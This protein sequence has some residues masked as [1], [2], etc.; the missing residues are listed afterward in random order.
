MRIQCF[1]FPCRFF[2]PKQY[3]Y[4]VKI[5]TVRHVAVSHVIVIVNNLIIAPCIML[6]E[7]IRDAILHYEFL[8][9]H[10]SRRGGVSAS[11]TWLSVSSMGTLA[12]VTVLHVH[13]LRRLHRRLHVRL[14]LRLHL[15]LRVRVHRRLHLRLYVLHRLHW[16]DGLR[17]VGCCCPGCQGIVP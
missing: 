11:F 8:A 9:F 6:C 14:H 13:G 16:L 10:T 15:W 3:R 12:G 4:R 7:K 1:D 5:A 17:L 2:V